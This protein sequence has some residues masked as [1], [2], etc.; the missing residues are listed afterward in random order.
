MTSLRAAF[1]REPSMT[2]TWLL[3]VWIAVKL[4]LVTAFISQSASPF[5]YAGF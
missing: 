5:I 1:G 2:R 3:L 4:T